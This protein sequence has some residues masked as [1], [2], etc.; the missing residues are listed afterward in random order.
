MCF[1]TF[2]IQSQKTNKDQSSETI[3]AIAITLE[4]HRPV[5]KIRPKKRL[6]RKVD[7]DVF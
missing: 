7:T 5:T 3:L 6:T 2:G 1:E 4:A